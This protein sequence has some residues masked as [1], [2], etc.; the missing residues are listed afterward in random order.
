VV[1]KIFRLRNDENISRLL[2][3][4]EHQDYYQIKGKFAGDRM[5]NSWKEPTFYIA[6]PRQKEADFYRVDTGNLLFGNRV[7]E[8]DFGEIMHLG[9]EI[10]PANLEFSGGPKKIYF[11]N[12][13]SVYPCLNREKSS[14][15]YNATR[16]FIVDVTKHEFFPERI[17]DS[18]VFKIPELV[19]TAIYTIEREGGQSLRAIARKNDFKGISFEEVWSQ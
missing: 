13:I 4:K 17:L 18:V 2:A 9:G 6:D 11:S 7:L 15:K 8:S 16:E 3:T 19:Q 1:T 14:F 12:I 10:L 5:A